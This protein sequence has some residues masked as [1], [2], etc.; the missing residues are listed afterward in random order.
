[1]EK[2]KDYWKYQAYKSFSVKLNLITLFFTYEFIRK[3]NELN[4]RRKELSLYL[5][6]I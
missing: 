2:Y 4:K 3:L 1:M 6:M 5:I